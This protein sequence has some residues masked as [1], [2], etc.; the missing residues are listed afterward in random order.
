ML[1]ILG[2]AIKEHR[3]NKARQLRLQEQHQLQRKKVDALFSQSLA[4]I[5]NAAKERE[6][7][8]TQKK[9]KRNR[10]GAFKSECT[11]IDPPL[12]SKNSNVLF[13]DE[14]T[15]CKPLEKRT[16]RILKVLL[17]LI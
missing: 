15:K 12:V 10:E 16:A 8:A 2:P 17:F 13:G 1:R 14:S 4:Q 9:Q 7:G 5:I 6:R 3:E 11:S